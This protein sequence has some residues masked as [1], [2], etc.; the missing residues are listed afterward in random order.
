MSMGNWDFTCLSLLG[1]LDTNRKQ[2]TLTER[3]GSVQLTS[4]YWLF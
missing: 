1:W 4:L 3:E 2:G